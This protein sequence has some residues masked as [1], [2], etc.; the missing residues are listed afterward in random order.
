MPQNANI[1]IS[2]RRAEIQKLFRR[3]ESMSIAQLAKKL[4][5]SEM[6]VRRDLDWLERKGRVRRTHGGAITTERMTFEFDFV[7]RRQANR[8]AKQAIARRAVK[9]VSP[10]DKLILDAGTTTL[11]LA[12]LL[13]DFENLTVITPSLAVASE[14][15]Y[16]PG[17]QTVLLGGVIRKGSPDLNGLVT[18]TVLDMFMADIAF[19]GA[20]GIGDDGALYTAD[21]HMAKVDQKI[22]SRARRTYVLADSTKLGRPAL[23]R[24][25]FLQQVDALITDENLPPRRKKHLRRLGAEV[26]LA[27]VKT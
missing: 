7:A 21:M 11:E 3:N 12:H 25:G 13:K 16:S 26:I 1:T 6:T 8:A 20:D 24:H 2:Q 19:Q 14:L 18:E 10:G 5:V 27:P 22:R 9:L 4:S 17:V 15:Q 23:T